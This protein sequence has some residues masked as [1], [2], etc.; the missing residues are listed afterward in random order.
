M[1]RRS[2]T[3][4]DFEKIRELKSRDPSAVSDADLRPL[5]QSKN[6]AAVASIATY[7]ADNRRAA[8]IPEMIDAFTH[9]TRNGEK[10]DPGCAAKLAIAN[11]LCA[12][13]HRDAG[14]YL[15]GVRTFQLEA[16][17]GPRV[18]TAGELRGR[19]AEALVTCLYPH[20]LLEIAPL[21]VDKEPQCRVGAV[22]AASLV[23]GDAGAA[24]IRLKLT[25]GDEEP[26]VLGECC[27]A[28]L[29]IDGKLHSDFVAEFLHDPE[30]D[31]AQ[32]AFAAIV[33]SKSAAG[34]DVLKRAYTQAF[35]PGSRKSILAAI[36][37]LRVDGAM[38]YILELVE[39]A[40][41]PRA[42]EVLECLLPLK[43]DHPFRARLDASLKKRKEPALAKHAENVFARRV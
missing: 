9:F 14:V 33:E 12:L 34:L 19:C 28:L 30:S 26:I 2:L 39:T 7:A 37:R 25:L 41:A 32:A 29:E 38:S 8:L 21:L 3:E 40:E 35:T 17:Y 16:S 22:R 13:D 10:T 24:L 27:A 36:A 6:A 15:I 4:A 43:D 31:V 42:R 5:L 1:A 18:D 23:V 11:A 20:A